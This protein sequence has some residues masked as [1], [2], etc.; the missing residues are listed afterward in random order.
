[1][2][3]RKINFVHMF[4]PRSFF[5]Y[6]NLN[7]IFIILLYFFNNLK[8]IMLNDLNSFRCTIIIKL[9]EYTVYIYIKVI[10]SINYFILRMFHH[11]QFL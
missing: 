3:F 7:N 10:K 4:C 5:F 9:Y 8:K 11:K 6:N 2:F 1:M